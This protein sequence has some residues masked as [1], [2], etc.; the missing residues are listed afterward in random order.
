ML[1]I[2]FRNQFQ[3]RNHNISIWTRNYALNFFG[4]L[5]DIACRNCYG[6]K[7]SCKAPYNELSGADMLKLLDTSIIQAGEDDAKDKCPR[8]VGMI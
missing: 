5:G 2:R 6:K 7:Y 3:S 8:Y 1:K 4:H